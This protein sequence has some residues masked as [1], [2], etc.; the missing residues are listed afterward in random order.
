MPLLGRAAVAMW[1]DM[2]PD[3][4][5]EFEDWH[6]H[7][8]FPERLGIPGFLR[9]SRWKN[10]EGT[11]GFF[12]MYE[13]ATYETLTS[14]H[15]LARLNNPTP[16]STKMMPH[17][18]NMVR[19]Q[20]RIVD[21]HGRGVAKSM[22]TIR[23]SPQD[24]KAEALARFLQDRLSSLPTR[25][26]VTGAHLLQTRTPDAKLTEEQKI[27]GHDA[28]ADWIVLV[29]GYDAHQVSKAGTSELN[30]TSL[31]GAGAMP[32]PSRAMYSLAY[33]LTANDI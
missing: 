15:Y 30:A 28:V 4:R 5:P 9:G 26:G 16:W 24:G 32:S 8:H 29:S 10:S 2:S 17:H 1:W 31:A 18:R 14:P 20:C 12:V 21:S 11:D 27:R 33:C 22:M 19:S 13:L 3:I 7:E 25:P 23:L 6:S